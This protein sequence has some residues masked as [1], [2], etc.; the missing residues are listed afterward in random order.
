MPNALVQITIDPSL[1]PAWRHIAVETERPEDVPAWRRY[2]LYDENGNLVKGGGGGGGPQ[3][4]TETIAGQDISFDYT[5]AAGGTISV[6]NPAGGI[7]LHTVSWTTPDGQNLLATPV[8][9]LEISCVG[10]LS[11]SNIYRLKL[12]NVKIT[13]GSFTTTGASGVFQECQNL[14]TVE[15]N[16]GA[17]GSSWTI[18]TQLFN[19][20]PILRAFTSWNVVNIPNSCFS[21][22][23]GLRN[24]DVAGISGLGNNV[25]SNCHN[26]VTLPPVTATS[27]GQGCFNNCYALETAD[28]SSVTSFGEGALYNCLALNSVL[29]GAAP[30]VAST[31]FQIAAS[32]AT[33]RK[34]DFYAP[35]DITSL[36]SNGAGTYMTFE[37]KGAVRPA[38]APVGFDTRTFSEAGI[39]GDGNGNVTITTDDW[40]L[41]TN[42]RTCAKHLRFSGVTTITANLVNFY[43]V[44]TIDFTGLNILYL[45]TSGFNNFYNLREIDF[46]PIGTV[47]FA[48]SQ[49]SLFFY[50]Y[51]LRTI[52]WP[53]SMPVINSSLMRLSSLALGDISNFTINVV[54]ATFGEQ[55][56][57]ATK[58]KLTRGDAATQRVHLPAA[59]E[60]VLVN[61]P[62]YG[63]VAIS[64]TP[65]GAKVTKG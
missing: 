4:W 28:F 45:L 62:T 56:I 20:T 23:N 9:N 32:A 5:P 6:S 33:T 63:N 14:R 41:P 7:N 13:C 11:M 26:L 3:S 17:S 31:A 30:T 64:N 36:I 39:S 42:Y 40:N 57:Y 22:C 12:V 34:L 8:K 54:Q 27:I 38:N 1:V 2:A 48:N 29:L 25:F 61:N 49:M 10:E 21:G 53:A 44:R 35:S 37:Y 19:I 46:S 59:N 52:A 47:Q 58:A 18:P 43:N 24:L 60:I 50:C 16:V 55:Y 15:I 51:C 65:P